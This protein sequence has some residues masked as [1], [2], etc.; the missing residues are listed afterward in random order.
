MQKVTFILVPGISNIP[1]WAK[2]ETTLGDLLSRAAELECKNEDSPKLDQILDDSEYL[3]L[4]SQNVFA[5]G[6]LDGVL[7]NTFNPSR[8]LLVIVSLG[9]DVYRFHLPASATV[10]D[11]KQQIKK[12]LPPELRQSAS[13][14]LRITGSLA[15]PEGKAGLLMLTRLPYQ[16][17]CFD[18]ASKEISRT[19][20]PKLS[21]VNE[22]AFRKHLRQDAFQ[23]G[24]DDGRW[25]LVSINWPRAVVALSAPDK[26]DEYFIRFRLNDYPA[27]PPGIELWNEKNHVTIPPECWP[28]WFNHFIAASYPD[29][30]TV[31]PSPYSPELLQLS[32]FIATRKECTRRDCWSASG[33]LTQ[34]LLPMTD[35]LSNSILRKDADVQ[36]R[37]IRRLVPHQQSPQSGQAIPGSR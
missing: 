8:L 24:I 15:R 35:Y 32:L 5:S 28:A 33:D 9:V 29:L 10:R 31:D 37:G 16:N 27:H 20:S 4:L 1:L 12:R 30:I 17:I 36:R 6:L 26:L 2:P 3:P 22:T 21:S 19:T 25:R 34:C 11:V 18:L 13:F 23:L 14:E 7:L